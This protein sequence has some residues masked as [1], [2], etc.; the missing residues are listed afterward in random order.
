ML[1]GVDEAGCGALMGDLVAAAVVLREDTLE[2]ADSKAV[3]SATRREAMA[4]RILA[5]DALCGV[6]SVSAEEIDARGFAW[7][8]REVLRR[9]LDALPQQPDEIVVDGTL[10]VESYR[11]I[12]HQCV[13][14]ADATVPAVSAASILAKVTRDARVAALCAQEPELAARYGWAQNKGYPSPAH[15]AALRE[16]GP[17]AWHRRSFR[18]CKGS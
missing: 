1:A 13:P 15:L 16:H 3:R 12:P 10:F 14:R 5:S 8:R 18:P 4:A 9:A 7:A 6:A 11:G 2:V 17:T